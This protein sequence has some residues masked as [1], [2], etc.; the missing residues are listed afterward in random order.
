LRLTREVMRT[1]GSVR[2]VSDGRPYRDNDSR[3]CDRRRRVY[4]GKRCPNNYPQYLEH[5]DLLLQVVYCKSRHIAVNNGSE[6]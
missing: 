2:D 6:V 3:P 4:V 1:Y 5:F